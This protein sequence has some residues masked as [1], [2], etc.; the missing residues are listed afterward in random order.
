[1]PTIVD[2]PLALAQLL[3]EGFV[4]NY[5]NGGAFGFSEQLRPHVLAFAGREDPTIR[6]EARQFL[7]LVRPPIEA[8]LAEIAMEAWRHYVPGVVWVM[9][10]AHWA[11]EMDFGSK[12]WMPRV[13]EEIGVDP[14]R[15]AGLND[16]TAIEFAMQEAEGF[17]TLVA[18]LLE[19]LSGSDFALAFPS[20]PVLCTIHH[21]KQLWWQMT[22]DGLLRELKAL[23]ERYKAETAA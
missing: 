7:H 17:R 3:D 12:A 1:M 5:H 10:K 8:T 23:A 13:L 18:A 2:Y 14:S 15:L 4:C 9:P 11:F 21:H 6:P 16:A 19:N 20:R 22:S